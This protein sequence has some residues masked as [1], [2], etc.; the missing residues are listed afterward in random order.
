MEFICLYI[1]TF[2]AMLYILKNFLQVLRYMKLHR[3]FKRMLKEKDKF[4]ERLER[5]IKNATKT[6][7]KR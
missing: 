2:G 4:F 5:E 3:E 7:K 6:K 1:I